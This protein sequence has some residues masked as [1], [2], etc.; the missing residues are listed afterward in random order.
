M[1]IY[2]LTHIIVD[3][4]FYPKPSF[5]ECNKNINKIK[6]NRL[7][8]ENTKSYLVCK[9]AYYQKSAEYQRNDVAS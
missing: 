9:G 8:F 4:N 5:V 2:I 1:N 7:K 6:Q 3:E